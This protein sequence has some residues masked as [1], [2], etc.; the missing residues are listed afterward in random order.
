MAYQHLIV[1]KENGVATVTVNR[2][3]V[4][5]A[6]NPAAWNEI[7]QVIEDCGRDDSVQ[8]VVFTGAGEAFIAGADLRSL[9]ERS[10]LATLEASSQK[11]LLMLEALPKP[12]IAAV[13]GY[14]LGGGCELAMA[15]D[16]RIA[17]EKAQFGQ[18]EVRV[19]IIPGAGGT[20]RLPRLVGIGKAKELIFTGD[21]IDSAEAARI[22][23]VNRVV[24][25]DA[26]MPC[27]L[28]LAGKI[29]KRG[30]LAVRMAKAAIH[31]GS[32]YGPGAGHEVERLAQ[33][34]LFGTD[35]R[36]E[37]ISAFLEKRSPRFKGR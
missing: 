32:Q 34:V 24:P 14:A 35:D 11:T 21:I 33:T 6:L 36:I 19:G 29:M 22:G 5:N 28:E 17:S 10:A 15:C 37:G 18:T 1:A 26:L 9:K 2:P 12:T 16:I 30:P 3:E 4:R 27:V 7:R 20:Q 13:N 23:L 31:A 8:V 25:H